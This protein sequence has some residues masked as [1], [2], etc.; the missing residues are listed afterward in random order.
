MTRFLS[1]SIAAAALACTCGS[2]QANSTDWG[3]HVLSPFLQQAF[4]FH[5]PGAFIDTYLFS[6][7]SPIA[8]DS[9]AA[10]TLSLGGTDISGGTY[11]LFKTLDYS[12]GSLA[13]DTLVG[14]AWGFD[15]TT[16]ATANTVAVGAGNYYFVLGGT[17]A[18]QGGSYLFAST[19]TPVPEPGVLA[20]VLAGLGLLGFVARR[21]K[22]NPAA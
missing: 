11:S 4:A 5:V 18:A 8:S 13:D 2:V 19:V 14:G 20:S 16:G 15:G 21:R 10:V 1:K 6:L 3:A 7:S 22:R 12:V 9:S 17:A